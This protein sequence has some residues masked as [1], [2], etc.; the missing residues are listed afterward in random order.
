M[1]VVREIRV[2]RMVEEEGGGRKHDESHERED[3][4]AQT[5]GLLMSPSDHSDQ[6]LRAGLPGE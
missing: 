3:R 6:P 4:S 2:V 5:E 1:V